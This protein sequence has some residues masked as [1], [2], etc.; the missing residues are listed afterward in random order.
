MI[1]IYFGFGA[2]KTSASLGKVIRALANDKKIYYA[3][4]LKNDNTSEAKWLKSQENIRYINTNSSLRLNEKD[5]QKVNEILKDLIE[6]IDN[7]D[8]IVLDEL[9]V[10]L[11]RTI[12]GNPILSKS[13]FNFLTDLC[14]T[15]NKN[16]V[17]TGRVYS[18]DI[19]DYVTLRGDIVT[20][21]Y[22]KKHVFNRHCNHCNKDFEY[23]YNY[24]PI[25]ARKL[26]ES[27]ESI[28]GLDY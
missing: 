28:K 19:R 13:T 9:L 8:L 10:C 20:N 17:I 26:T 14:N 6:N 12:N 18:R 16:M 23:Y 2:G 15:K 22:C 25:C 5:I 3:Q 27:R 7:Y 4:F 24:C 11:D 1:Y 21:M